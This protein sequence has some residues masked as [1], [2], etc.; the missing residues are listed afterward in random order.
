MQNAYF[1][2][3]GSLEVAIPVWAGQN[4]AELLVTSISAAC[5]R[6]IVLMDLGIPFTSQHVP[7][8]QHYL[9]VPECQ[10]TYTT[11]HWKLCT[12][13]SG[14][15]QGLLMAPLPKICLLRALRVVCNQPVRRLF[16]IIRRP[17]LLPLASFWGIR[18]RLLLA[19][20]WF[21]SGPVTVLVLLGWHSQP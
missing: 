4:L 9:R 7:T 19:C 21:R 8:V 11:Q 18:Q 3:Q 20:Q 1:E 12:S 2:G 15:S 14:W 13:P 6:S 17:S 5:V 10:H 16:T